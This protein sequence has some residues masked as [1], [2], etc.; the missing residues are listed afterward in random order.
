MREKLSEEMI[1]ATLLEW[2]EGKTTAL[3]V[4]EFFAR[5]GLGTQSESISAES[6]EASYEGMLTV[7]KAIAVDRWGRTFE[8]AK[9]AADEMQQALTRRK[10]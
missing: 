9:A 2:R 5:Y 8:E 1:E 3:E 7:F 6:V 4:A 10:E